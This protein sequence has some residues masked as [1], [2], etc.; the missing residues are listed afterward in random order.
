MKIVIVFC[1]IYF[2]I[3]SVF[4]QYWTQQNTNFIE[5]VV[6]VNQIS[7]VDS[8][9]VWVNGF[10]GSGSG[11][12]I[13][14]FSRTQ[15][16]GNTWSAGTYNGFGA[17][18]Y[19]NILCAI[20]YN[21][22]FVIAIDTATDNASFWKT[23]D[24]GANWSLVTGVMNNAPSTFA[25]G[26]QF[27][28]ANRG[29]C[30]GDPVNEEFDIYITNDG[31][32]TWN[33]V[34]NGNIQDIIIA[35]EYG[36]NG[37]DCSTIVSGGIGFFITNKGRIYKTIDYGENWTVIETYP[38]V[39]IPTG[40]K[41]YASSVNYIIVANSSGTTYTWKYTTDGGTTWQILTPESGSFYQYDMCYVPESANMY[42]ST[43]PYYSYSSGGQ[44]TQILCFKR[45]GKT[46][47]CSVLLSTI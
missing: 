28:N 42:I 38:F 17:T 31:G 46:I 16:G 29:F 30:Y 32:L 9:I 41:I 22:A 20:S 40:G 37:A 33:D 8:N 43:S 1:A 12:K 15:D 26:V 34:P 18:V 44:I 13:K 45:L 10:N 35:D 24:G 19:P 3:L 47:K 14:V 6:G 23:T 7:I 36:Y 11:A 39:N 21:N 25:D 2:H 27:W 4:G 5:D